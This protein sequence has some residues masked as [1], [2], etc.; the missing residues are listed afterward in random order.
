[1]IQRR[2]RLTMEF[3]AQVQDFNDENFVNDLRHYANF[4]EI[5]ADREWLEYTKAFQERLYQA[6]V[7]RPDLVSALLRGCVIVEA[8]DCTEQLSRESPNDEEI[9]QPAFEAL[10][11]SDQRKWKEI[12]ENEVFSEN[13]EH[14]WKRFSAWP[15]SAELTDLDSGEVV[16]ILSA[17]GVG[18]LTN[19]S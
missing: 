6:V 2:F 12:I 13:S 10:P 16:S 5:L 9:M 17:E 4:D 8:D 7:S 3:G 18:T 15:I 14:V 1:M 19:G 11:G